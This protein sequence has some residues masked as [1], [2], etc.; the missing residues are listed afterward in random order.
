MAIDYCVDYSCDAK[1][2]LGT[3]GLLQLCQARIAFEATQRSET[4]RGEYDFWTRVVRGPEKDHVEMVTVGQLRRKSNRLVEFTSECEDCPANVTGGPAGCFGRVTYPIDSSTEKHLA[5]T[6]GAIT[7][8][9]APARTF[10]QWIND[11]PVDGARVRR[12]RAA[13]RKGVRFFELAD[14]LPVVQPEAASAP[15]PVKTEQV[16]EM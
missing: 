13:V 6:A 2:A 1:R 10:V 12:M 7:A 15:R 14:P 9:E 4:R 8:G 16:I 3:D 11:G 5:S